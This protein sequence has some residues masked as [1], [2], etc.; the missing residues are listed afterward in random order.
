MLEIDNNRAKRSIKPFVICRKNWMFANTPS[1]AKAS[2]TIFSIIET[3]KE[4][5]LELCL[6]EIH[7]HQSAEFESGRIPRLPVAVER[8]GLLPL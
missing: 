7:L 5:G 8:A 3:V 6:L 2:A 4:N 1:G